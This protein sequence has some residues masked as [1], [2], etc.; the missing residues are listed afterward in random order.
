MLTSNAQVNINILKLLYLAKL[1]V[2][3]IKYIASNASLMMSLSVGYPQILASRYPDS[4]IYHPFQPYLR[5]VVFLTS[6]FN[7]SDV[8]I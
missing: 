8:L 1:V 5:Y 3:N 7:I 4:K 2:I 6:L